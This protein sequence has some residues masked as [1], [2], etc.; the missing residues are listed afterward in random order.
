MVVGQF[1]SL[2]AA[3]TS[4]ELLNLRMALM[5]PATRITPSRDFLIGNQSP[6]HSVLNSLFTWD[7]SPQGQE[8]WVSVHSRLRIAP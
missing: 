5:H 2:A 1:L 6:P 3:L 8:Y 4:S 7:S